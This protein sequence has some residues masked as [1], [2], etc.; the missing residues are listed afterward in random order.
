MQNSPSYTGHRLYTD[1]DPESLLNAVA[2]FIAA[3]NFGV[4][5]VTQ[6]DSS[7]TEVI[8]AGTASSIATLSSVPGSASTVTLLAL[9]TSRKGIVIENDSSEELF[10]AYA[11]TSSTSAYTKRIKPY[12]VWEPSQNYT[13]VI[14]GIWS[15]GVGKA[16]I[17]ELT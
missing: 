7:G 4:V 12:E 9:N 14:S 13:G 11:A 5:R 1:Q 15:A 2:L 10:V 17:T 8:P 16:I 6:Y 3:V